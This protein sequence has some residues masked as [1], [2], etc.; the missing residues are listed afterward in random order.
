MR[1][2]KALS[3]CTVP[4]CPELIPGGGRC[5]AHQQE[6]RKQRGSMR[7]KAYDAK[8]ERGNAPARPTCESIRGVSATSACSFPRSCD[9]KPSM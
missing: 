7:A 2:G 6:A 5:P 8:W 9:R 3:V 4:G 1:R